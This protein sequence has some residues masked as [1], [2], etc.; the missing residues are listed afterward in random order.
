MNP[1]EKLTAWQH[2]RKFFVFC[3]WINS[4]TAFSM[5]YLVEMSLL[6]K[7]YNWLVGIGA[8]MFT[9]EGG[10]KDT[11]EKKPVEFSKPLVV[12]GWIIGIV[13]TIIC[14][15]YNEYVF[16]VVNTFGSRHHTGN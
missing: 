5:Q 11:L 14:I 1:K 9:L 15:V 10:L 6:L 8:I 16:D 2:A 4:I 3:L 12:L 7:V 13:G